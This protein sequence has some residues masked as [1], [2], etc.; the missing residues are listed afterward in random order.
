MSALCLG[1]VNLRSDDGHGESSR[2][3]AAGEGK[4]RRVA[5]VCPAQAVA[6]RCAHV[7]VVRARTSAVAG[8]DG[9]GDEGTAEQHIEDDSNE[10]EEGDTAEEAGQENREDEVQ[11]GR[12]GQALNGL[13]PCWDVAVVVV[14]PP[15]EPRVDAEDDAAAAELEGVE[16]GLEELEDAA[17]EE[18]HCCGWWVVECDCCWC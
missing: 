9:D 18:A 8:H 6:D 16:E 15:Q 10:G 3:Q 4:I 14:V 13:L 7:G 12:A 1:I 17:A 11:A 5:D 2:V